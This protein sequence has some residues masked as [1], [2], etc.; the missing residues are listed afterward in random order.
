MVLMNV[1][2]LERSSRDLMTLECKFF[3][4]EKNADRCAVAWA[5]STVFI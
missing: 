4:Q 1:Y 2:G 3:A 5:C